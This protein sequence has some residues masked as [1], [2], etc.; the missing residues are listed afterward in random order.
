MFQLFVK[1]KERVAN[2][3][4]RVVRSYFSPEPG[5][6]WWAE[7]EQVNLG[8]SLWCRELGLGGWCFWAPRSSPVFLWGEGIFTRAWSDRKRGK[9]LKEKRGQVSIRY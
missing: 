3:I 8:I 2:P 6:F 9:G 7:E 5:Q 4:V 1:L